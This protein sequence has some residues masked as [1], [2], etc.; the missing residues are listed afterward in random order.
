MP[1][2]KGIQGDGFFLKVVQFF[3]GNSKKISNVMDFVRLFS[4][5]NEGWFHIPKCILK[6]ILSKKITSSISII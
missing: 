3:D 6:V 1:N 4:E 5:S 2:I